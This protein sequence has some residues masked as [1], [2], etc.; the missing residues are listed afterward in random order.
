MYTDMF[1]D[2]FKQASYDI[3]SNGYKILKTPKWQGIIKATAIMQYNN[4]LVRMRWLDAEGKIVAEHRG[5]PEYDYYPILG[6]ELHEEKE[7]EYVSLAEYAHMQKVSPDTVRQKI[8]RGN[9]PAKKLGRNWCIR[10]NTP[11]TDNRRKNV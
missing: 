2:S 8:L 5:L 10:K 1:A 4:G 7:A 6:E 11:Y 9:L 3:G